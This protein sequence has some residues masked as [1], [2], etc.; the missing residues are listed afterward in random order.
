MLE[1]KARGAKLIVADPRETDMARHAD[2]W[3]R[4]KPGTDV[5]LLNALA[6]VI[7]NKGLANL[8]YIQSR[9]EN[10]ETFK[11]NIMKCTPEYAE[12]ITGVPASKIVEAALI[13]GRASNVSTYYTMGV[14][15]HTSGVDNVLSIA[16]LAL[17]TGNVGKVK[18]GV[19]PLRGQNNVREPAIWERCLTFILVIS[20]LRTQL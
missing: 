9:T 10:Y 15:Q 8:D 12:T 3:L 19:N 13:I 11:E 7:V 17:L 5:A 6:N 2:V 4:L 20:Q 1:A 16:N 18:A 14:T